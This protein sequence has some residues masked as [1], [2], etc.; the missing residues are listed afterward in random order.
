MAGWACPGQTMSNGALEQLCEALG[1]AARYYDIWGG[2]RHAPMETRLAVLA[3]LGFAV[4]DDASAAAALGVRENLAWQRGL[5]PVCV[6]AEGSTELALRLTVPASGTSA[7]MRW[8][9]EAEN[10]AIQEGELPTTTFAADERRTVEGTD[11]LATPIR[12]PLDVGL[13]YHRV[14]LETRL[15]SGAP[16]QAQT[17]LVVAPE[18]CYRPASLAHAQRVWGLSAQL[19]AVRSTRNWGIGDFTDLRRLV[20]FAAQAG[21]GVVGVSPLHALFPHNPDHA[22]PYSPSSRLFLNTLHLDI[23]AIP[24]FAE[25]GAARRLVATDAFQTRLQGLRASEQLRYGDVAAAKSEVLALLYS[26]FRA[27]H[28][29]GG[30]DRARKFRDFQIQ[31]GPALRRHA[32]YE[33]L[34][35][36]LHARNPDLWGWPVWPL[37][38]RHPDGEA[39]AAF[40]QQH[41][42]EIEAREY[43]QWQ[44][45]TQLDRVGQRAAEL[46]LAV[47]LY[48]DLAVGVDSGGAETWAE[49]DAFALAVRVG[50]PPDDFNLEG[51]NWGLPPWHPGRL[52]EAGYAPL[53]RTLRTNMRA[54]GAL[55]IDHIM[56][57]ARQ[58][59]I[60]EGAGPADGTYVR[61]PLT[62]LLRVLALESV[63]NRCLVVGEDLGTVPDEVREGLASFDVL[64]YR[65]L[66]FSKAADGSF[67][68][69]DAY[70]ARAVVCASTHDL[71]TLAGYWAGV[72][73]EVRRQL[74]LF[75]APSSCEAQLAGRAEDRARL[76]SALAHEGLLPAALGADATASLEMTPALASAI[77]RFLARSPA[78]LL[79]VQLEDLLGQ[80]EQ[81]N[82]PG[83]TDAY[84][85]WRRKLALDLERW[86]D[87]PRVDAI[88]SAVRAE[89]G[90]PG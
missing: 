26:H 53:V 24:E 87:E 84:P 57:L 51:Q 50:A 64:S 70:P 10:G 77:H 65:L 4:D 82:L 27:K 46:G 83:T 7:P 11:W 34:Q 19:Y 67:L 8:R 56:G 58:F 35:A 61:Y 59:W 30:D 69:P 73:I 85:N 88:L 80:R 74:G 9:V 32:L 63:R 54:A 90:Q 17:T 81:V 16:W 14:V 86:S 21:A 37:A 40:A 6:L 66:Y 68:P 28:V 33:A 71:P 39:V 45:R 2:E 36:H 78:R 23:E 25:C 76:L 15:S 20:E 5:P 38:Y 62:D 48:Q 18:R 1:I 60:P 89:R 79:M 72:D 31:E 47:G 29:A 44:A 55:R 12:I 75:P 52:R 22:S 13:G 42:E 43:A 41:P 49:H 3:A